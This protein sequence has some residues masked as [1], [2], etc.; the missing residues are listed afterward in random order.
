MADENDGSPTPPQ[1][2]PRSSRRSRAGATISDV[3]R[4]AGV[5]LMTVSRVMNGKANVR[6]ETRER[7]NVAIKALNYSPSAAARN[8][9][10]ASEIR[11]GLLY[12]N[13]SAGY[14]NEFLVGSLDQA[15]RSNVQLVVQLCEK[16]EERRDTVE[17]LID[18]GIDGVILPPPLCDSEDIHG[19]LVKAEMP[20]VAVASGRP[21]IFLSSVNIDDRAAAAAMTRHLIG[22]GH[23][24]IGFISG[25]PDQ[26][27]SALRLYGYIDALGEAGLV[28]DPAMIVQGLFTY[29]SGLGAAHELLERAERPT[30]I[31]ASNDDMAAAVVSLAHRMGLDVPR[32]LTVVGFDDAPQATTTWPELTTIRQ[33]IAD[34]SRA[35]VVQLVEDIRIRRDGLRFAPRHIQMSFELISRESDASPLG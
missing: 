22:L 12:S 17:R 15:A 3:A 32:D 7:V 34:M 24:K 26:T 29:R 21:A 28:S 1:T 18:S 31:F 9:A 20:G 33:P 11:I 6:E 23:R 4:E 14:L 25:N 8:L 13:P 19:L 27:A 5:S 16:E 30:A 10:A 2:L 35:A